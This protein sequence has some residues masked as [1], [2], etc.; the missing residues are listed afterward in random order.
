ML[1]H[2]IHL[3]PHEKRGG[4]AAGVVVFPGGE[5]VLF[6]KSRPLTPFGSGGAAIDT[7]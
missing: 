4:G 2:L 3:K 7:I 1:L 5:F 6:G